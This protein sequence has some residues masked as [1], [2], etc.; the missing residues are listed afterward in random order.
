MACASPEKDKFEVFT[1]LEGGK[2]YKLVDRAAEGAKVFYINGNKIMEGEGETTVEKTGVYRIEMDFSIAS[3]TVREVSKMEFYFCPSGAATFELPYVG[4]GVFCGQDKIEFKQEGW[5]RDQRYKFL[6]TYADGSIQYWGTKNTTDSNPGA[7]THEDPYFY[8]METPDN[9]WDQKWKLNDEFDGAA[10]G[11][12]PGAITKISV[13]FNVE[14]YTHKVE[15][16][17]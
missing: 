2:T 3:V 17:N 6:M 8:I 5:G 4:N 13:I 9:Q 15:L 16:A 14:N 10:D 7:A 12:N 1:K 11:H